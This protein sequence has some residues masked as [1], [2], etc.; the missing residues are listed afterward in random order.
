MSNL[1]KICNATLAP[2]ASIA[3]LLTLSGC[4]GTSEYKER[5]DQQQTTTL[6]SSLGIDAQ[7]KR[8]EREENANTVRYVYLMSFGQI[9]GYYVIQG[10]V[11]DAGTQLAPEQEIICRWSSAES[12]QAVDSARDNGTYGGDDGESSSSLL[13]GRW[14]RP[15]WTTSRA[16]TRS[17]ST[18]PVW[19]ARRSDTERAGANSL[20][21]QGT[22]S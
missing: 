6:D 7:K 13:T 21:P 11:Y 16:T 2:V 3:L 8:L 18:P 20:R 1:K 5:K 9:V 10:G 4:T 12:C 15:A 14:S 17:P 22:Y 19:A